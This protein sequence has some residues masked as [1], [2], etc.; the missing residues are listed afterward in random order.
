M[1][2]KLL[3]F[4]CGSEVA[5]EIHRS[6]RFSAHFE[7]LGASSVDDHGKFVFEKYIGGIP[8]HNHPDFISVVK[9]IVRR[10][11][12]DAIFPAMD[13]V[14]RTLKSNESTLGCVVIGSSADATAVCSLKSATYTCLSDCIPC[15]AW[16]NELKKIKQYPVF[17]KPDEGYGSRNV[18]IA[19]SRESAEK[20]LQDH[21]G[22]SFVFCEYLPGEEFTVDCFSSS[23][24]E[25]LFHGARKR[26]RVSNG[27]SVNTV[28]S[29]KHK[30]AIFKAAMA[31]NDRLQPRGAWFF[32]MK[33]NKDGDPV[34]LEVAARLGGSS[35]YFRAKGVNFAL[36]S[37]FDAFDIDVQIES[38]IYD[39]ELDRALGSRY[40]MDL[41]YDTAYIDLDDCLLLGEK[42][43]TEL[44]KYIFQARNQG[45]VIVLITQHN[46]DIHQTLK[47]YRLAE[48][49]DQIIHIKDKSPKSMFINNKHAIFI[50]D[51]FAERT[52][53]KRKHGIPVFSPDMVE[54]LIA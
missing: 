46:K 51:S 24:R 52:E 17:I 11:Q 40:R 43:N 12:V 29:S 27:I 33:E 22:I 36:L 21:P 32:Q 42:V 4:P 13:A 54:M 28:E 41:T 44:V 15:P 50:D 6:L 5:L 45:I 3:V 35:S 20:F 7:L 26:A 30:E 23:K 38:N 10:E 19:N 9:G 49:F 25:L 16:A 1:K 48:L 34:L 39:V 14:A 18:G 2:K 53:V 31:I 8:F 47:Q 37:A